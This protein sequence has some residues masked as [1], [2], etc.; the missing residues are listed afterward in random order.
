MEVSGWGTPQRRHAVRVSFSLAERAVAQLLQNSVE[1]SFAAGGDWL[2]SGQ[3]G[4]QIR[5]L[6]AAIPALACS[7]SAATSTF[8]TIE[9]SLVQDFLA[10]ATNLG[11]R[12][13]SNQAAKMSRV[14]AVS[15]ALATSLV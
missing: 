1:T 10:F 15:L 9:I 3:D 5:S 14:A 2:Q 8:C 11:L 7:R 4:G 6:A 12:D 13:A